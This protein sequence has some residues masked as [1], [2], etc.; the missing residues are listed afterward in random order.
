VAEIN[1]ITKVRTSH[2]FD[3]KY[4]D[5]DRVDRSQSAGKNSLHSISSDNEVIV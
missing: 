5:R 1:R 2:D 3:E 4:R